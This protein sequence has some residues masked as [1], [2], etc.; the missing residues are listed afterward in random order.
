MSRFD[1]LPADQRATLQLLLKQGKSYD[2]LAALLRLDGT[3]VRERALNALD[4]LGPDTTAGLAP[5]HQ[6]EISDYLLGQQSASER[7]AT[8]SFLDGSASGRAWARALSTQLR[9]L[10]GD[11]LPEVPAEPAEAEEASG[12]PSARTEARGGQEQS[13]RVGGILFL[14]GVAAVV[15]VLVVLVV[16]RLGGGNDKTATQASD[17]PT[18]TQAD[19]TA[20][21]ATTASTPTTATPTACKGSTDPNGCIETQIPLS[22]TANNA[23]AS[24]FIIKQNGERILGINGQD[25]PAN[26]PK[27]FN[28]AV[29]LYSSPQ[30]AFRL[31]FVGGGVA[32]SGAE[33]GRLITGADPAAIAKAG[34]TAAEKQADQAT[35]KAIRAALKNF[36]TYKEI[37]VTQEP[38]GKDS[39]T[40]GKIVVSGRIV[41]PN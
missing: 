1:D 9:P 4:A 36:Y 28:Y 7:A 32:A 12:S 30:Q 24:A 10:A 35:A 21:T 26:D 33:K 20:T 5:E 40:P 2:E 39:K 15:A 6:D 41:K 3:A 27:T 11:E 25:F 38:A 13:S 31:G 29:W 14:L 8:R 17:T 23:L 18:A 37:I 34:T 16:S 19:T 22:S